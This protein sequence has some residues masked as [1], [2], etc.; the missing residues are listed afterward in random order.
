MKFHYENLSHNSL[1]WAFQNQP[2]ICETLVYMA[3]FKVYT[4]LKVLPQ[5]HAI[6]LYNEEVTVCILLYVGFERHEYLEHAGNTNFHIVSFHKGVLQMCEFEGIKDQIKCIDNRALFFSVLRN[7]SD[8]FCNDL[9][10][11]LAVD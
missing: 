4:N 5:P 11:L 6:T 7:S 1:L 3:T 8:S 9:K 2:I 10:A